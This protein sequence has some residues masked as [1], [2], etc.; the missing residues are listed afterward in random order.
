M[1]LVD[2]AIEMSRKF[3]ETGPGVLHVSFRLSVGLQL[4]NIVLNDISKISRFNNASAMPG[5]ESSRLDQRNVVGKKSASLAVS[6]Y[7]NATRILK[8]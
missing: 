3:M 7:H 6:F 4:S 8:L 5:E 1:D 2:W